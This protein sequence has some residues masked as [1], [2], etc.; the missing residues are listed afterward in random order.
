MLLDILVRNYFER[1]NTFKGIEETCL[2]QE[3]TRLSK[4]NDESIEDVCYRIL[5]YNGA[6]SPTA[7]FKLRNALIKDEDVTELCTSTVDNKKLREILSVRGFPKVTKPLKSCKGLDVLVAEYYR[8]DPSLLIQ[9]DGAAYLFGEWLIHSNS[10]S[11]NELLEFQPAQVCFIRFG[12]KKCNKPTIYAGTLWTSK[13]LS[14]SLQKSINLSALKLV[15]NSSVVKAILH[16]LGT[17]HLLT[18]S[19]DVPKKYLRVLDYAQLNNVTYADILQK[20][21]LR[22]P[23]LIK[24]YELTGKAFMMLDE[25]T[26]MLYKKSHWSTCSIDDFI[27][28]VYEMNEKGVSDPLDTNMQ[29]IVN[30]SYNFIKSTGSREMSVFGGVL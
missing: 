7:L 17:N 13:P 16:K 15:C 3:L 29:K 19:E 12:V 25:Q 26:V 14:K 1:S 22:V 4:D 2:G 11:A 23:D 20:F 8:K 28:L 27:T 30:E 5:G 21:D 18:L 10:M 24:A 6:S 9:L